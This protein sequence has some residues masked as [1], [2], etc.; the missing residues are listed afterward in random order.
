MARALSSSYSRL[1]T[2]IFLKVSRDARM[3][4]LRG[5]GRALPSDTN[6]PDPSPTP[7]SPSKMRSQNATGWSYPI[8]VE[9][10]RSWGAE[11]WGGKQRGVRALSVGGA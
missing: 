1:D 7:P 11:I 3:E 10:S 8:H 2:H 6:P 9:Y 5:G 4:P